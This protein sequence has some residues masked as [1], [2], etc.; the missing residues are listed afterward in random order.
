M[1]A[2]SPSPAML[3]AAAAVAA[4]TGCT[5]ELPAKGGGVIR[6]LPPARLAAQNTNP[7][8]LVDMSE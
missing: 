1:P 4:A 8:D 3:K 2:P 7:A 5:V 6:I